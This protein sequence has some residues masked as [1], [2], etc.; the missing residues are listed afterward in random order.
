MINY[1]LH[2]GKM[3][4]V[5]NEYPDNHFDAIPTDPPYG[6]S[7]MAKK[8]DHQV[9]TVWQ[10]QAAYRV[11]KPGGYLA[12]FGGTRTYHRLVCNIEDAG[13]EI[14][15]MVAWIHGQGFPKSHNISDELGTALKPSIEPIVLARKPLDGTVQE[16]YD[17][18]G[19][20]VLNI[21][22][23][24]VPLNGDYKS[25]ANGRPSLTG[26]GDK[27]DSLI[28]NQPDFKGRWPANVMHDGSVEV[29]E[30][31]PEAKGQQGDLVNHSGV[32]Q[33]PNGIFGS[34]NSAPDH[35]KRNDS[36]SAARFFYCSKTSKADR[37]EGLENH[38]LANNH[39][40]VKP[41]NLMRYVIRLITPP[42]GLILD[43][44][45]GSGSTLKAGMY[46][47]VRAVGIDMEE[48]NFR[49]ADARIRFALNNRS[50]QYD[51]F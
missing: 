46:E 4:Y 7:F 23:C 29:M 27:Y 51:L 48:E 16:N 36:G 19:T 32:K 25:V 20:G 34:Y 31:F 14:R 35:L 18:W 13:F 47:Y 26:L 21:D 1:K 42:D 24:R 11:L 22:K 49:I 9:P 44:F 17:R 43:P 3:E 8:W 39:P 41:T 10:W 33:S 45:M 12:A 5:L 50:R 30:A 37:E 2:H 6:L 28:A 15:D 38:A 40:T